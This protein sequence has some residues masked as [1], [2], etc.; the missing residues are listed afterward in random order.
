MFSFDVFLYIGTRHKYGESIVIKKNF[1]IYDILDSEKETILYAK[2][3]YTYDEIILK[4]I[5]DESE[6]Q[7]LKIFNNQTKLF[8][9]TYE[10]A[11]ELIENL[12]NNDNLE[13]Y[14]RRE[15]V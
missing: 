13:Y 12:E 5:N 9:I 14:I 7:P 2:K 15:F 8:K 3:I 1:N 10:Q 6:L 11:L 4:K